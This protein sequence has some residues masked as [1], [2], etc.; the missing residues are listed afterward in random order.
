M[1]FIK[2]WFSINIENA[3]KP[4]G[5]LKVYGDAAKII[6]SVCKMRKKLTCEK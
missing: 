5:F 6:T 2:K 1:I 3:N 4:D